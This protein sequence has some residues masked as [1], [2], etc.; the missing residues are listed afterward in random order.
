MVQVE[1]LVEY[2]VRYKNLKL[3]GINVEVLRV[4]NQTMR[5]WISSPN[6]SMLRLHFKKQVKEDF[7]EVDSEGMVPDMGGELW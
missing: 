6:E 4:D 1:V 3:E 5:V 7:C 2:S